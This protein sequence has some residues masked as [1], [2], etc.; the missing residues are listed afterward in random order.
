LTLVWPADWSEEAGETGEV[1]TVSRH[2]CLCGQCWERGGDEQGGYGDR[3]HLPLRGGGR[4]WP[5]KVGQH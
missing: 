3:H 5:G 1:G 2:L 4:R